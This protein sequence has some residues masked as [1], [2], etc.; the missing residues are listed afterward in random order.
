MLLNLKVSEPIVN[1]KETITL[2]TM[3]RT[4]TKEK[5]KD[6]GLEKVEKVE[7]GEKQDIYLE[8]ILNLKK[9]S[10]LEKGMG[11][12]QTPNK[13]CEIRV[14]AVGLDYSITQWLISQQPIIKKIVMTLNE[15]LTLPKKAI[16]FI[17]EF[18]NLLV[19]HNTPKKLINLINGYLCSFAP[20]RTGPNL[21]INK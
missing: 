10:G 11:V 16:R 13:K 15:P 14:R 5:R 18:N 8:K 3:Q 1:F 20:K 6:S 21:L 12:E 7:K 4:R 17:N 19:E 9:E 2:K